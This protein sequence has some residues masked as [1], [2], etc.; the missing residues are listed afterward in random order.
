MEFSRVSSSFAMRLHP[1]EQSWR[2]HLGVDYAAPVGT[3]VRSVGDG[4][5]ELA[6]QQN[7]YGNV[8][9]VRHTNER[10]TLYAHLSRID[11]KKGQ[12]VEQGQRIGAV[13]ATG[14]A[15]GSHLHFEFRVNGRHRDPLRM[16]RASEAV[17]IAPA[18]HAEFAVLAQDRGVQL[19][20]AQ[21][22]VGA[23]GHA[24]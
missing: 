5:V 11:V 3:A 2:A 4:V 17:T 18:A 1:I 23:R 14:W 20:V 10:S 24:E 13:G 7:G 9:Q 12:R 8:I 21:T 19:A 22:L 6:G 16:A 15:T